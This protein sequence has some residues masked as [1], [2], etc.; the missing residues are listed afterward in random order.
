M[1][2][3][4]SDT[5]AEEESN[6]I[7]LAESNPDDLRAD[8]LRMGYSAADVAS[9]DDAKVLDSHHDNFTYSN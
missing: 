3:H 9:M 8:L 4:E 7:R 5:T 1:S 6:N 2:Y